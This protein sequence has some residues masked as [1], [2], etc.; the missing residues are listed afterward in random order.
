MPTVQMSAA[1]IGGLIRAQNGTYPV[2]PSGLITVDS[3]DVPSLLAAGA[4]YTNQMAG[5]QNIP[6]APAAATAGRIVASTS[7]ANGTLSIAN[8]PDVPRQVAARVDPG[9]SAITAGTLTLVYTAN[10]GAAYTDA[11]S[12]IA[13]ASTP[14]TTSSALGVAVLT[15]AIVTGL[16]G[17]TSPK[18]QVNDT[19][20]LSLAVPNGFANFSVTKEMDDGANAAIGTV[21]SSAASITPTATPNGTHTFA[22]GFL[23][24][25]PNA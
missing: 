16:A 4:F 22:F 10:T 13:A 11:I 5:M 18:I 23:A 17:G 14:V 7:L 15:S 19:N 6:G 25:Y 24:T 12:L 2:P 20:S 9:T 3:R 8:Q 1:G 21:A